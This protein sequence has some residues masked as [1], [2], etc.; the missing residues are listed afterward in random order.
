M[1]EKGNKDL[2]SQ[3]LQV[4]MVGVKF[5]GAT[6][7]GESG[8]STFI[9]RV[10]NIN[11]ER[12]VVCNDVPHC[13]LRSWDWAQPHNLRVYSVNDGRM[14][15]IIPLRV[16]L[17]NHEK[18]YQSLRRLS[19]GCVFTFDR[20]MQAAGYEGLPSRYN[21]TMSEEQWRNSRQA[22]QAWDQVFH[23]HTYVC[24]SP[25]C[26]PEQERP[27]LLRRILAFIGL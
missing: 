11:G 7:T 3:L 4:R 6:D 27:G 12:Y 26:K 9:L 8:G 13:W 5:S 18:V 14:M 21:H 10:C 22:Q 23:P 24:S 1:Q 20:A 2:R 15:N 17:Q 16:I 19:P 25:I